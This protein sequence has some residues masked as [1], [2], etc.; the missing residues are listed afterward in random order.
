MSPSCKQE[1]SI[2]MNRNIYGKRMLIVDLM[3][4]TLWALFASRCLV[5]TFTILFL[6]PLTRVALSFEMR[7]HSPWSLISAGAF[8][9]FYAGIDN[10]THPIAKMIQVFGAIFHIDALAVTQGEPLSSTFNLVFDSLFVLMTLWLVG[11][12]IVVSLLLKNVQTIN[13]RKKWVWIYVA[14]VACIG[15]IGVYREGLAGLSRMGLLLALLPA[16][17]WLRY[18]W[19]G[20]SISILL[21]S[22]RAIK[23][24]IAFLA[25]FVA[26]FK[27][28]FSVEPG[29]KYCIIVLFPLLYIMVA[30]VLRV[31][32]SNFSSVCALSFA[33]FC[34]LVTLHGVPYLWKILAV[35]IC[36]ISGIRGYRENRS[37]LLAGLMILG[38]PFVIAPCIMGYNPYIAMNSEGIKPYAGANPS[39]LFMV[40]GKA[41][42]HFDE[43]GKQIDSTVCVYGLRNRYGLILPMEYT[44][45]ESM[46]MSGNY[47]FEVQAAS[48]HAFGVYDLRNK[49]WLVNP[50]TG[51]VRKIESDGLDKYVLYDANGN[52]M[53]DL[54]LPGYRNEVYHPNV[55]FKPHYT[56][57]TDV[58]VDEFVKIATAVEPELTGT[59]WKRVKLLNPEGYQLMAKMLYMSDTYPSPSNNLNYARAV[60]QLVR[61]NPR[62]KGNMQRAMTELDELYRTEVANNPEVNKD[63]SYNILR[64]LRFNKFMQKYDRLLSV[65]PN[66]EQLFREYEAWCNLMEAMAMRLDALYERRDINDKEQYDKTLTK[67]HDVREAGFPTELCILTGENLYSLPAAQVSKLCSEKDIDAFFAKIEIDSEAS[68]DNSYLWFR[69]PLIFDQWRE[70]REAVAKTLPADQARSYREYTK[71]MTDALFQSIKDLAWE[72][73]KPEQKNL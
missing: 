21:F 23:W 47:Y 54:I 26:V 70:S 60:Y 64:L 22:D 31:N 42:V 33:G 14:L 55:E 18:R 2:N 61:K 44:N 57:V 32:K 9:L 34:Y 63:Q 66:N 17:Y 45:L 67:W 62:Y 30:K 7:R 27:V 12:P 41:K 46:G 56:N 40:Y 4:V 5:G 29:W 52:V 72:K 53:A 35:A 20:R 6:L 69:T 49:R 10:I 36:V 71:V 37:K 65:L 16:L 50:Q 19:E 48:N 13:W 39:G 68:G 43:S 28:G 58:G 3:L 38:M 73:F 15:G 1:T 24:Y 8:G 11:M 59:G 25:Y 51:L